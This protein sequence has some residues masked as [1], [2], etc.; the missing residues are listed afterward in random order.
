MLVLGL[1]RECP[2]VL[3]LVSS[4]FLM[5]YNMQKFG[6]MLIF[7]YPGPGGFNIDLAAY[8]FSFNLFPSG[9]MFL[10]HSII[11]S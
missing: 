8:K 6:H 4:A 10:A 11:L 7:W 1:E 9:K 3:H 2:H 5:K